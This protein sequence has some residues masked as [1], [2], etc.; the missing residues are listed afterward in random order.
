MEGVAYYFL[1]V[2]HQKLE[3]NV[4]CF[5]VCDGVLEKEIVVKPWNV[6]ALLPGFVDESSLHS[7]H[8][9]CR[10]FL[11]LVDGHGVLIYLNFV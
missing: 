3:Q 7:R 6:C 8:A 11:N 5:H 10:Q 2:T 1:L 4:P 9:R